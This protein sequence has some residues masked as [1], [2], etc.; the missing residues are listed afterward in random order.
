MFKC[1]KS[2]EVFQMIQIKT[3]LSL[4][5]AHDDEHAPAA[6]INELNIITT[7]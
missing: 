2:G 7:K 6:I 3:P 1:T 4:R 5:N